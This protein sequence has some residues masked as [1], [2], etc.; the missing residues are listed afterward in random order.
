MELMD[1]IEMLQ[2]GVGVE[3]WRARIGSWNS[4]SGRGTRRAGGQG[5]LGN[6]LLHIL[7]LFFTF[8]GARRDALL[9]R[10]RTCKWK[11]IVVLVFIICLLL[12]LLV[13]S[14]L[15]DYQLLFD[16]ETHPGPGPPSHACRDP[17][18]PGLSQLVTPLHIC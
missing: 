11:Y 17:V 13:V 6:L 3:A 4:R 2:M 15:V 16:V 9:K 12:T 18:R 1:V 5:G 14:A 7:S 10:P 8:L